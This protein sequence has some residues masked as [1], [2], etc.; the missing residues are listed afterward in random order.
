MRKHITSGPAASQAALEAAL[1]TAVPLEPSTASTTDAGPPPDDPLIT[2]RKARD[3]AGGI[4]DM[5]LWRWRRLGI[6]PPPLSIRGRN[7]WRK[8]V[9]LA[10][11][12]QAGSHD[13]EQTED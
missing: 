1:G 6:I 3:L 11:L 12:T 10:A 5:T 9:F 2:Q 13:Q 7:Y 4:S 8:S